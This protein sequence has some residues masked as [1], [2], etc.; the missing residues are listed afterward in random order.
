MMAS[1]VNEMAEMKSPLSPRIIKYRASFVVSVAASIAGGIAIVYGRNYQMD[2]ALIVGLVTC[3]IGMIT[4]MA[5]YH[6]SMDEHEKE[7][8]YWANSAGLYSMVLMMMASI[9][10]RELSQPI[11][12]SIQTCLVTGALVALGVLVWKRFL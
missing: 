11:M 9:L 5:M 12:I 6:G 1:G 2:A 3:I 10:L 7:A 4:S 8:V